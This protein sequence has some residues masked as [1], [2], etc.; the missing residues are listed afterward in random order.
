MDDLME[1]ENDLLKVDLD[2]VNLS[3]MEHQESLLLK[4]TNEN[5]SSQN[6]TGFCVK[7]YEE[8]M[9]NLT[10]ENFNLRL[11]LYFFEE[12]GGSFPE[13]TENLH[14]EIIDLKVQN[15][16]LNRDLEEK[17]ELLLQASQALEMIEKETK[18]EKENAEKTMSDLNLKIELLEEE[19][20]ALQQ[21]LANKT[22]YGNDTGYADFLGMVDSKDAEFQQ[23]MLEMTQF[24]DNLKQEIEKLNRELNIYKNAK[25]ECEATHSSILYERDEL[26][27]KLVQAETKTNEAIENLK[28]EVNDYKDK[29]ACAECDILDLQA[30]C[31]DIDNERKKT[32]T[33]LRKS[34]EQAK[35]YQEDIDKLEKIIKKKASTNGGTIAKDDAKKDAEIRALKEEL[36]KAQK[37]VQHLTSSELKEKNNEIEYL[38]T[39]INKMKTERQSLASNIPRFSFDHLFDD[40]NELKFQQAME[41]KKQSQNKI[42]ELLNELFSLANVK[43]QNQV[44]KIRQ[45]MEVVVEKQQITD[46]ALNRCAELCSYTLEHLHELAIFLSTLL[47]QK[48]FRDSLSDQSILKIQ[49]II[50]KSLDISQRNSID[51][52]FSLMPHNISN[53]NSFIQAARDSIADIRGL[54]QQVIIE[55]KEDKL[56]QINMECGTCVDLKE[57]LK[58]INEEY[59]QL[60]QVNQI[61]EDEI[62]DAKKIIESR[63]N[64]ITNLKEDI[65]SLQESED[66][67][68]VL[69]S[70][71][72]KTI[73]TL[74]VDKLNFES[75]WRT[76]AEKAEK[77][78]SRLDSISADL[79]TNWVTKMCYEVEVKKLKEEIVN[80]EAQIAAIRMEFEELRRVADTVNTINTIAIAEDDNKENENQSV[81]DKKNTRRTIEISDDRKVLLM[82]N[83]NSFSSNSV[84]TTCETC[85]K[86]VNQVHELKKYLARA[87]VKLEKQSEQKAIV[88]RHIQSQLH[89]TESFIQQARANMENIIKKNNSD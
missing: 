69:L 8:K 73:Q 79:E 58:D 26:K 45:E 89:K 22:N 41:I 51:N 33:L 29:W 59:E 50:V 63:D 12:K 13:G 31:E 56:I 36:A 7:Q 23:R 52:R 21:A 35:S 62:H 18:A 15:E 84:S 38:T 65:N 75:K 76:S 85:P 72:N 86:L 46:S 47:Q 9:D 30:K 70:D 60:K 27:D 81:V 64:E 74:Q 49:D 77:L 71:Y 88:D 66:E 67:L 4:T 54:Q 6:S 39:L 83:E 82:A 78:Q 16:Q 17:Q 28:K 57:K 24:S 40:F 25:K 3:E 53:F 61:L 80:S 32:L 43:T 34:I 10:K 44:Q 2:L 68:N 55:R 48:E 19:K 20:N 5:E 14:K 87:V 37:K 42:Q 1:K 11:R